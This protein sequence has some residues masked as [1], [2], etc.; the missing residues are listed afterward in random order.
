[1]AESCAALAMAAWCSIESMAPSA[2]GTSSTS[3]DNGEVEGDS[4]AEEML[5]FPE[6]TILGRTPPDHATT[7]GLATIIKRLTRAYITYRIP[8]IDGSTQH[9]GDT[10]VTGDSLSNALSNTLLGKVLEVACPPTSDKVVGQLRL[11]KLLHCAVWNQKRY[12][13]ELSPSQISDIIREVLKSTIEVLVKS[14]LAGEEDDKMR[15][16]S[17]HLLEELKIFLQAQKKRLGDFVDPGLLQVLCSS[18]HVSFAA[19]FIDSRLLYLPRPSSWILCKSAVKKREYKLLQYSCMHL[20]LAEKQFA[21]SFMD[22]DSIHD[23][24]FFAQ[25]AAVQLHHAILSEQLSLAKSSA[26]ATLMDESIRVHSLARQ[27]PSVV[28]KYASALSTGR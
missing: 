5:L 14:D 27:I 1:M 15:T 4:V 10:V 17:L 12:E 18:F 23:D 26:D 11:S 25:W 3:D 22:E 6:S 13:E 7:S 28:S 20:Q 24:C 2:E 8:F 16:S 19:H 9:G 21:A